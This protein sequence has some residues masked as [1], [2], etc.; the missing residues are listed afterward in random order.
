MDFLTFIKIQLTICANSIDSF[1]PEL[2]ANEGLLQ[3]ENNMVAGALIYRDFSNEIASFGDVVNTRKPAD[4]TA[5]RKDVGDDITLQDA[6]APNTPVTLNQLAHTSFIIRD[7]EMSKSFKDLVQEFLVPAGRSLAQMI[8]QIVTAQTYQFLANMS[9]KLGTTPTKS[10]ILQ[11]RQKLNDLKAPFQGRRT[12]LTSKTETDLLSI[13]AFTEADKVGDAGTALREASLGRKLGFDH[14]MDQNEPAV[15]DPVDFI[16]PLGQINNAGGYAAGSTVLT[17]DTF[18]VAVTAG[19]WLKI[20]GDD[21]PRRVTASVG[22]PATSLTV[23]P[24]LDF[25]VA[26]NASITVYEEGAVNN[27]GGY[28]VDYLKFIAIDGFVIMPKVGQGISFLNGGPVY[29][30]IQVTATTILL[31]RPLEAAIADNQAVFITPS[32]QFNLG[33]I[34]NAISLVTRPLAAPM[35]NAG[36]R[37]AVVN[38]NNLSLRFVLAYDPIK[39]GHIATLDLL[40]GIKVLDANLGVVMLG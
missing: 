18:A 23:T 13:D 39:Q 4:F 14:Y 25:A 6:S 12:W 3:V 20:A 1:I 22:A 35:P 24:P 16:S 40:F 9:G 10:T 7:A 37:A 29:S 33:F 21:R 19:V 11:T 26:D 8:D 27:V 15:L 28:A 2:W 31:D 5:A 36:A 38:Y 32:G 17:V 30:V 34:K